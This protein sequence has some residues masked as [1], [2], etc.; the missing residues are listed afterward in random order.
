MLNRAFSQYL[1]VFIN[2]AM[3]TVARER[4][5]RLLIKRKFDSARALGGA[6]KPLSI[7]LY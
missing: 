6:R 5:V 2:N 4:A 3:D 7:R 1:N